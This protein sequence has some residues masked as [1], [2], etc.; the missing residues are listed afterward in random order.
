MITIPHF[1]TLSLLLY[2]PPS[3]TPLFCYIFFCLHHKQQS[4]KR[5]YAKLLS[6]LL[7]RSGECGIADRGRLLTSPALKNADL[8]H[9]HVNTAVTAQAYR[10]D[11]LGERMSMFE[12][13]ENEIKQ[14]NNP[15][16]KHF[17]LSGQS[18]DPVSLKLNQSQKGE[19]GMLFLCL[20]PERIHSS[21][22]QNLP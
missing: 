11:L 8:V 9:F 10:L 3:S 17:P 21:S 16:W 1:H 15:V 6:D 7:L 5:K 22:L 12:K 20:A 2:P 13:I 14:Q 19:G 18:P 4:L